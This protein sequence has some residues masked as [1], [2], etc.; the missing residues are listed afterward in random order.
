[1]ENYRIAH[2]TMAWTIEKRHVTG[3]DAK[4]PGVVTWKTLGYYGKLEHVADRLF[5]I[6]MAESLPELATIEELQAA[7]KE[8]K[9]EVKA[10]LQLTLEEGIT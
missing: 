2:D 6:A 1:M 9:V 7:I 8:A 10:F 4:E 3:E 5:E